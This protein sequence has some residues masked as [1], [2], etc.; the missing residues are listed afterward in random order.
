MKLSL[1]SDYSLRV[2]MFAA[3]KGKAFQLD[4]VASAFQ[5]SKHHLAKIV[6]DLSKLGYLD[7]R[8]GRGGGIQ[9]A[10]SPE[11][12]LIGKLVQETEDQPIMV[13]CFDPETNTCR[14]DGCCK[15]KA[16]LADARKAFY[17]SLNEHTLHSLVSG[18]RRS[19]LIR[20]LLPN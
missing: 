4:E 3:V 16:A 20:I 15:L 13:E 18:P 5:I 2:L 17:D 19:R 9:L 14:L 7:T 1:Y 8:R 12:I 10:R 11:D 6:Q